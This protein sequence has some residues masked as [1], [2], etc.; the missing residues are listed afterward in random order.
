MKTLII[1]GISVLTFISSRSNPN[2]HNLTDQNQEVSKLQESIK[3]GLVVYEDMCINC[4]LTNG[5]GV[6]KV[7]PPLANSD[8]LIEKQIESIK[9]IKYGL[10]GEIMVNGI[11]Y[12]GTMT[13]LGLSDQEVADIMNY[14]NN[15]WGN[16]I[17][18][19]VTVKKVSE[20]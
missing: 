14:I 15:S 3:R 16:S 18:N 6:E 4:H 12:N 7:Y 5:L 1:I 20:L 2:T 9:A 8:Y 17:E 19:F 13:P 10:S 11:S